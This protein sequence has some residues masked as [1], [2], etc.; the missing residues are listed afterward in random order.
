MHGTSQA[1]VDAQVLALTWM[2]MLSVSKVTYAWSFP[3]ASAGQ[4]LPHIVLRHMQPFRTQCEWYAKLRL[5][6]AWFPGTLVKTA[7]VREGIDQ[8]LAEVIYFQFLR[9]RLRLDA[10]IASVRC[11]IKARIRV[12]IE[13][14]A[15]QR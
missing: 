14:V 6:H 9:A 11:H 15:I 2:T 10:R 5:L 8:I 13:H 1:S 12:D 7:A 4:Q 3:S